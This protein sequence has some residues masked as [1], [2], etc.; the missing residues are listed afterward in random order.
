MGAHFSLG[1]T[2]AL[3]VGLCSGF[4]R[5]Q[6]ENGTVACSAFLAVVDSFRG[7]SLTKKS[8]IKSQAGCVK[9]EK[10][11]VAATLALRHAARL[12]PQARTPL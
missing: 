1:A 8:R 11:E 10:Y 7:L 5:S 9:P 6:L 4:R 2:F 12:S 3:E